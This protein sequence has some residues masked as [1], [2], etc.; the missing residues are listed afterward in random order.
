MPDCALSPFFVRRLNFFALWLLF[1][2]ELR[3]G[4]TGIPRT[5]QHVTLSLP[6]F[7]V[8]GGLRLN[9]SS[10]VNALCL[11]TGLSPSP[12]RAASYVSPPPKTRSS[13]ST[14]PSLLLTLSSLRAA[15]NFFGILTSTLLLLCFLVLYSG[16]APALF[17]PRAVEMTS[18]V[19]CLPPSLAAYL[20]KVR[21]QFFP[22]FTFPSHAPFSWHLPHPFKLLFVVTPLCV[23]ALFLSCCM[24]S[25]FL[26]QS[27]PS[28]SRRR[29]FMCADGFT[30]FGSSSPFLF[31]FLFS[32][33]NART[34]LVV[35]GLLLRF[36]L[37]FPPS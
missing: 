24:M 28:L 4:T 15:R 20:H 16:S 3:A 30:R 29:A 25:T 36:P 11:S 12:Q 9:M 35:P 14:F 32:S 7:H 13:P 26:L 31:F 17:P 21:L 1:P 10:H 19:V 6:L 37:P 34:T 27:L 23:F 5:A 22:S 8:E 18:A 2:S 33:H